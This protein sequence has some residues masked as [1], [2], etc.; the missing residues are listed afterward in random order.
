MALN[1]SETKRIKMGMN[2][3]RDFAHE[4]RIY[5]MATLSYFRI[6]MIELEEF[7][8]FYKNLR[9]DSP[10]RICQSLFVTLKKNNIYCLERHARLFDNLM[11]TL[12]MGLV[13]FESI[14]EVL[15]ICKMT[16]DLISSESTQ[17]QMESFFMTIGHQFGFKV[18]SEKE[19]ILWYSE[20]Q[21][22][23]PNESFHNIE[24]DLMLNFKN[25]LR[26]SMYKFFSV[27]VEDNRSICQR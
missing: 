9:E 22:V 8:E 21:K 7:F 16:E 2:P 27:A 1:K 15:H 18:P 5:N 26:V 20:Y 25:F 24:F 23:N 4:Y 13:S 11:K 19:L 12:Y 14:K 6:T 10:V 17:N 3:K